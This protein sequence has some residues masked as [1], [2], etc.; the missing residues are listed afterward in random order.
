MQPYEMNTL[1]DYIHLKDKESWE[2]TRTISYITAQ[3]QSTKPLDPKDIMSFPWETES[4]KHE[5][6]P[7]DIEMMMSE[8]KKYENKLN[9][10]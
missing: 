9:N 6:T 4:E 5:D 10:R 7:E 3:C 2:Q 8:M 1:M